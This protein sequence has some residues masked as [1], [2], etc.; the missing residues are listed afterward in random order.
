MPDTRPAAL[1]RNQNQWLWN[2]P[3]VYVIEN[4]PGMLQR[5]QNQWLWNNGAIPASFDNR[6]M[7]QRN[8]NQWLWNNAWARSPVPE[9]VQCFN[10]TRTSGSGI[11][12]KAAHKMTK[13]ALLQRNQNQW[14]WNNA[15][16]LL[17]P[18][19]GVRASTEPEPVAL[20]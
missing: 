12:F 17:Y 3:E 2:N 19:Q 20:E 13:A 15:S 6:S 8:Q 18:S 9:P 16:I 11:T 4:V 5:N 14:L 1:Q 10:G 7:L